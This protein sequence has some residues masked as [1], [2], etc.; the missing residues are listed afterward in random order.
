MMELVFTKAKDEDLQGILSLQQA[1]LKQ[2]L[3]PEEVA[4]QGFV[5]VVHEMDLIRRLNDREQHIIARDGER[6]VGYT[7]A[8]TRDAREDIP[9]LVSLFNQLETIPLDNQ[10]LSD[11]RYIVVGQVCVDKAYR[12]QHVLD[13]C[14]ATY[15]DAYEKKYEIAVT[16]I[17]ST[18]LRSRKAH[19]RIGFKEF[20][21][22]VDEAGTEW[23]IVV[24]D[25]R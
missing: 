10:M 23:V 12:G 21:S 9:V 3:S 24:W 20:K 11:Y 18:N 22:F 8:M 4:S 13:R 14:Y 1:N 16:D 5:T 25:W 6:V 2:H 7:L 15:R 19:Q 17:A